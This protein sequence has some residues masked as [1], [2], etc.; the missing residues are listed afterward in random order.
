MSK[1]RLQLNDAY[2]FLVFGISCH[3]KDYRVAWHLNRDLQMTFVRKTI[4]LP[5]TKGEFEDFPFFDAHDDAA[6]LRFL[7]LSNKNEESLLMR[8]YKQYDFFLLV[9]GY[10][11]LFDADEFIDT[12][13]RIEHFQLV[14]P[15]DP[16]KFE[17]IQYVLFEE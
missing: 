6:R 17:K 12:L 9:E 10:I 3:L 13:H 8:S 5:I 4:S 11:D 2:E 16:E 7:L 1:F 15:L 14:S